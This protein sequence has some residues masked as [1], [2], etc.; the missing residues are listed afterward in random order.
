MCYTSETPILTLILTTQDLCLGFRGFTLFGGVANGNPFILHRSNST[1]QNEP[2]AVG[3]AK[4]IHA[5]HDDSDWEEDEKR[6]L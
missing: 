6:E 2:S 1:G 4:D 3:G 5:D